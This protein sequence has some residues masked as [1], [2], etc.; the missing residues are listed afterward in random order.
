LTDASGFSTL[1]AL[2]EDNRIN[3]PLVGHYASAGSITE[4]CNTGISTP[5]LLGKMARMAG[6]DIVL[7]S[8]PYSTYPFLK[9][10]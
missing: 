7:F 10:R 2:S 1:Q 5:L 4:S 9:R 8:S 6:A 3:V